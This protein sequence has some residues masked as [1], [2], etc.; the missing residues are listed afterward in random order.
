MIPGIPRT[1]AITAVRG[2]IVMFIP[3]KLPTKL[4][5]SKRIPPRIPL[6]MSLITSRIGITNSMP[7]MYNKKRPNKKAKTTPIS[8]IDSPFYFPII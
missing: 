3:T 7:K 8:T 1:P 6:I 4:T 2:L 5:I